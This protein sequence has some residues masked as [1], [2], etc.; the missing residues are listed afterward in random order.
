[1]LHNLSCQEELGAL[2]RHN[3]SKT[4]FEIILIFKIWWLE[5]IPVEKEP[6]E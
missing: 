4:N 5:M 2:A 1:M 6:Y 3:M